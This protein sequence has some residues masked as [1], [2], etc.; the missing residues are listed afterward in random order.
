MPDL[1]KIAP[2]VQ[3]LRKWLAL[4]VL[5]ACFWTGLVQ[6]APREVRVGVYA[7]EPKIYLLGAIA[8]DEGWT[9]K[10]VPCAW[11]ECLQVLQ[12]GQ[13][14]LLPDL[15][16]SEQRAQLFDFHKIPALHSWSEIYRP[17]G[18]KIN[19]MLDLR[20][21]RIAVLEDSIQE[22]YLR[23]LLADFGVRA[24]LVMVKS[25]EAGFEMVAAR[26]ADVAVANRFFG[27]RMAARHQLV[28][29]PILFQPS[30]LFYGSRRGSNADLLS[31]I[32]RHLEKWVAASGSP[33]AQAL[34]KW[35]AQPPRT[36][37]PVWLWWGLGVLLAI[38]SVVVLGNTLLRRKVLE[39]TRHLQEDKEALRLQALVL[40]QIQDHVTVTDLAG[41]VTYV[42]QAEL[43]YLKHAREAILN[44]HVSAYGDDPRADATQDQIVAATLSEGEWQGQV[45]NFRADG[46][47]IFLDL[48]TSL[49][50]NETGQPVAMVGI[51]TDIT[52]RKQAEA[53]LEQYRQHLEQLVAQRTEQLA[54]A[55][56][57]AETANVAKSAF[58]A[59]MSHE[60]RTPLNAITG[61]AHLIRRAGLEAEQA[62][63]LDK[64]EAAGEHLLGI[65]N[66]VLDLS[67]IEAGKFELEESPV[68]VES[69]VG[70]VASML[71]ERAHAKQLDFVTEVQ[72]LPFHCLG[73]PT[74]L[75]QALLNYATNAVK[76]TEQ[77]RIT[78]RVSLVEE[79]AENALLRFEVED[80][81]IG[82]DPTALP[83]LFAAFEQA[84][85]T[86]TRKYGGTGL[87]LAITRRFARLMGGDAGAES[88]PGVGSTFWF[89]VRL[90][91][92][93]A[94]GSYGASG[95]G[96]SE[97]DVSGADAETLLLRDYVGRRILLA[98]DEPV[99]RE[100][101]LMML[102][103]AGMVVDIA[104][105]GVEAVD[106]ASR[107][108]Y[109]LILMDMQ[110]PNMDGLEATRQIRQL[111]HGA[112][113]PIIAMTANAF[114]E[115][116]AR[117]FAA[118]MNDFLSKPA[119]PESLFEALLKWLS[120]SS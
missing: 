55:K 70:N 10:P 13:I 52:E 32:D 1:K 78:L 99:N 109:D 83:K 50:R 18:V 48:R 96:M 22:G 82:I 119:K 20:G 16:Y 12:A 108:A 90:K 45:V 73:D 80:T 25:L 47:P 28:S 94:T 38:L 5:G 68:R 92:G 2:L 62:E 24:E 58:L 40:D 56:E 101:S 102:D 110:M 104:E 46:S 8:R 49:V 59:N 29:S 33:Y 31:A 11:Q 114:A 61:M 26:Q 118:G 91:K 105:D 117:C 35:M 93:E 3:W 53:E 75:Q 113:V 44:Q 116:K 7:N 85:N 21:K 112:K 74:R 100:I 34:E 65:I 54:A 107:N 9:L 23:T 30:Q 36:I 86:T 51:G 72:P 15:A 98:E 106:L 43:K 57:L 27:E 41:K 76:F 14:D 60:I 115:D 71:H 95:S 111:P 87:G 37:V 88:T 103:D 17:E 64:L 66:A 79:T 89:S 63:R 81:G 120:L 84:D 77:G 67:K 69:L 6:A 39:Q 4:C 42:N 19:N 97:A